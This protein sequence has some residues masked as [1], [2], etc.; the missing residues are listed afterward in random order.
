MDATSVALE[1]LNDPELYEC[2]RG[3]PIFRSHRRTLKDERGNVK[4]EI[5]VRDEDLPVIAA[6]MR[7]QEAENGVCGRI[8]D[9]HINPDPKVPE[10]DQPPLVGYMK[11]PRPGVFGP[12]RI[13]CVLVDTFVRR[14]VLP[15]RR[16]FRSS[17]YYPNSKTITGL[18]LM[19]RDPFLDLGIVNYKS[20][21]PLFYARDNGAAP[22][23]YVAFSETNT[24]PDVMN[25]MQDDSDAELAPEEA[26]HYQKFCSYAKRFLKGHPKLYGML[27]GNEPAPE[28]KP[29]MPGASNVSIPG[30]EKPEED[31][32]SLNARN[33][34]PALYS[35]MEAQIADLIRERE[36]G[37]CQA[38]VEKLAVHYK[39]DQGKEVTRLLTMTS[40]ERDEHVAYIKANYAP[41]SDQ[42]QIYSGRVEGDAMNKPTDRELGD[43]AV[44]YATKHGCTY[45]EGLTAVKAGKK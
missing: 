43:A 27:E 41:I 44:R 14:D 39:L 40:A 10:H 5:V 19:T 30:A 4:G 28:P 25:D 18:A 17:E 21:A 12:K 1:E 23:L 24:M 29:A 33:G 7:A 45:D 34:D 20:E 22:Y 3:V 16:P 31:K 26:Q 15:L 36:T 2:K 32:P 9:G 6:N 42:I 8:T 13:P 11:N 35:R 38:I 37:K